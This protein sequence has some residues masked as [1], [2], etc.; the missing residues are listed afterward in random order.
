MMKHSIALCFAVL[1]WPLAGMATALPDVDALLSYESHAVSRNGITKESRFQERLVRR[2]GFIWTERVLP[3]SI[4]KEHD[5]ETPAE[6][7]THEHFDFDSAARLLTRDSSGKLQLDYVDIARTTVVRVPP[8]EYEATGF[9]ST[10]TSAA[11]LVEPG[12]IKAMKKIDKASPVAGASWYEESRGRS[13]NRVLWSDKL[14]LALQIE[15]GTRDGTIL[16]RTTVRLQPL[17]ASTRLP[18][19]GLSKL[20]QKEYDDFM[21]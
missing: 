12:A 8:G 21:D 17:T 5:L 19:L 9:G 20:Q 18:W 15:S 3:K 4:Y 7:A 13:Y 2:E 10:W 1:M 11:S 16:R 14:Q 6:H